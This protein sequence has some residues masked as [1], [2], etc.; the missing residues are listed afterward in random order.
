MLVLVTT[1]VTQRPCCF[2]QWEQSAIFQTSS[3]YCDF[4]LHY[5]HVFEGLFKVFSHILPTQFN[6]QV[7]FV[8]MLETVLKNFVFLVLQITF[9]MKDTEW[10]N[11]C[12][13]VYLLALPHSRNARNTIA[14][15]RE[16]IWL[17]SVGAKER[18]PTMASLIL[19]CHFWLL[20]ISS[21]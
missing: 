6:A 10:I 16:S 11:A 5:K 21:L 8:K 19:L 1:T 7:F 20:S 2:A 17:F 13:T 12:P 4:M 3:F 18:E 15:N 9:R 14:S